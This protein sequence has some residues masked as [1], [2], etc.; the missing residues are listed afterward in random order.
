MPSAEDLCQNTFLA[1]LPPE[2]RRQ[3]A[4]VASEQILEKD[5]VLHEAIT[6][7][8][9]TWFPCGPAL[10]SYLITEKSGKTVETAMVGREGMVGGLTTDG[11]G[12]TFPRAII[13]VRGLFIRIANTDIEKAREASKQV[14][15]MLARYADCLVAQVFQEIVCSK[16]HSV[17]ER[18]AKWLLEAQMRTGTDNLA[19]TQEDMAEL[20]GVGRTFVNRVIGDL[21]RD[22]LIE[23]RRGHMHIKSQAGLKALS[24][25]CHQSVERHFKAMYAHEPSACS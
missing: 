3:L 10:A 25:E 17:P 24:C 18:A 1:A 5:A 8:R 19:M 6:K 12:C 22:G 13:R 4:R 7:P 15:R 9:Y 11:H 16:V 20:L 2:E 23:T 14:R 21:R